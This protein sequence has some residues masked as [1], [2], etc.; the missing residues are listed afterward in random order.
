[1]PSISEEILLMLD[2]GTYYLLNPRAL[3]RVGQPYRPNSL[4]KTIDRL[5]KKELIAKLKKEKKIY[6]R[7]TRKGK[8]IVRQHHLTVLR[9]LQGWDG[10]WRLVFFDIPEER[11]DARGYLRD[12]LKTLGFGKAQRSVW[13]SPYKYGKQIELFALKLGLSDYLLQVTTDRF[14]NLNND[15]L[16]NLCWN[17]GETHSKYTQLLKKYSGKLKQT[18]NLAKQSPD[19]KTIAWKMFLKSLLWDYQAILAKDPQLPPELLP[20][21]WGGKAAHAF[22]EKCRTLPP[23]EFE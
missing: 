7:L 20:H 10:K 5:Q 17:I 9:S 2:E 1:M 22:V 8:D 15:T 19:K 18:Q 12:Y 6:L 16:V 21:D 23:E 4:H 13:I 14:R 11:G 3:F